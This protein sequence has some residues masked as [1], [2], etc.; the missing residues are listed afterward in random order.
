[1]SG[2]GKPV[3]R[4]KEVSLAEFRRLWESDLSKAEIGVMLGISGSAVGFRA[5]TRGLARRPSNGGPPKVIGQLDTGLREFWIAG[6]L[7][8]DIAAHFGVSNGT[9]KRA[10]RLQK[11]PRRDHAFRWRA[12]TMADYRQQQTL[13][14]MARQVKVERQIQVALGFMPLNA[15]GFQPSQLRRAEA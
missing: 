8:D 12:I 3:N 15:G 2:K 4:G 14:A 7:M 6:V 9:V 1:M 5:K 10:A 13:K 11:L